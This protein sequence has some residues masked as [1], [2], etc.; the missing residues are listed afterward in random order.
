MPLIFLFLKPYI[1]EFSDTQNPE[2]VRPHWVTLIKMQP[3]IVNPV[4]K[5]RPNPGAPGSFIPSC[6]VLSGYFYVSLSLVAVPTVRILIN[7][8]TQQIKFWKEGGSCGNI[9]VKNNADRFLFPKAN[10]SFCLFVC[11]FIFCSLVEVTIKPRHETNKLLRTQADQCTPTMGGL[12]SL[13]VR[14]YFRT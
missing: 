8:V 2:N 6:N 12:V 14:I 10:F 9:T 11:L 1:P 7:F 13:Y 5:M 4:M 3:I